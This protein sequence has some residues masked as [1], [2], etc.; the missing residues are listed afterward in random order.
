M[1]EAKEGGE[2]QMNVES[3]AFKASGRNVLQYFMYFI[4]KKRKKLKTVKSTIYKSSSRTLQ[5]A[6]AA[7]H[8]ILL[9]GGGNKRRW[10]C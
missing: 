7:L 1:L 6:N 3:T 10:S 5:I 4:F 8:R 2:T 9:P